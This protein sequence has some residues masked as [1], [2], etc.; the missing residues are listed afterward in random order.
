MMFAAALTLSLQLERTSFDMLDGVSIEVVVHN[1]T[2]HPVSASFPE[3]VEY[4]IDATRKGRTVW[5]S[6]VRSPHPEGVP[7]HTR[8]FMPGPTILAVYVWN[9]IATDGTVPG[10]GTYTLQARLLDTAPPKPATAALTFIPPVPTSA[11]AKLKAGDEVTLAGD[12]DT[13]QTHLTDSTGTVT[14]LR[15]IGRPDARVAVRGYIVERPDGSR[16]L[17]VQRWGTIKP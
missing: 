6:L 12:L 14:L 7:M 16:A 5:T 10:P 9:G 4:A 1:D 17:F 15:R 13:T 11:I 2:R 8:V 3:P